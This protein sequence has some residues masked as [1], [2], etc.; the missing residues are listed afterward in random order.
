MGCGGW[1]DG[2]FWQAASGMEM[3]GL[4]QLMTN[5][6]RGLLGSH[7]QAPYHAHGRMVNGEN[8]AKRLFRRPSHELMP[9]HKGPHLRTAMGL[10]EL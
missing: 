1:S 6:C 4:T 8:W 2:N 7:R 5:H 10:V 3:M 9:R